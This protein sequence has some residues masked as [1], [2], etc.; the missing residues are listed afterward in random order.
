MVLGSHPCALLIPCKNQSEK[1]GDSEKSLYEYTLSVA[2]EV[3]YLADE[4]YDGCMKERNA[5][6]ADRCDMLIAY[7]GKYMGGAAQTLRMAEK[8]GKT[9]YNLY[10]TLEK[11][12]NK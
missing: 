3:E 9:V 8:L 5:A 7:V 2:D 11:G 12:V 1:W 6:L 4:Y 10:P